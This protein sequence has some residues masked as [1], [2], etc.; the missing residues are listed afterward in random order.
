MRKQSGCIRGEFL[1]ALGCIGMG[2]FLGNEI[3]E[4]I[5]VLCKETVR[6]LPG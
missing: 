4:I 1:P 6:N 2:N 3:P 5:Y